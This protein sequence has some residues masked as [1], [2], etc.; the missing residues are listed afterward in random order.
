MGRKKFY[1]VYVYV[2]VGRKWQVFGSML[3]SYILVTHPLLMGLLDGSERELNGWHLK[4]V[5]IK[6]EGLMYLLVI[7]F[8]N[9]K[10]I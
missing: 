6:I 1:Q 4:S 7:N 10:R 8:R 3:S 9:T 2:C 5:K